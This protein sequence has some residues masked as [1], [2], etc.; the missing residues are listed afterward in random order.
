MSQ[1]DFF[2][3]ALSLSPKGLSNKNQTYI[4]I[5]ALPAAI[6]KAITRRGIYLHSKQ[7]YRGFTVHTCF[8]VITSSVY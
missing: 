5:L 6:N 3:P 1:E 7:A 4:I 8:L 2:S